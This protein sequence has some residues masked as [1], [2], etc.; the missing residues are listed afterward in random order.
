MQ[1][2]S[3]TGNLHQRREA[4]G[5][6]KPFDVNQQRLRILSCTARAMAAGAGGL[7]FK[8]GT[9]PWLDG[10]VSSSTRKPSTQGAKP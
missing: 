1:I 2:D 3:S 7:R 9:R 5:I 4:V 10:L 8:P 6:A